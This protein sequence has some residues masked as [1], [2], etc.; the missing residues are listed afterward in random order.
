[1][2]LFVCMY[3]CMKQKTLPK[4]D[5]M[6]ACASRLNSHSLTN[7]PN[8]YAMRDWY[9]KTI[10][11]LKVY[12]AS[13]VAKAAA[14]AAEEEERKADAFGGDEIDET[15]VEAR[16]IE[17]VLDAKADEH[18]ERPFGLICLDIDGLGALND[19]ITHAIAD[20]VS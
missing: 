8:R 7:L 18:R 19:C 9:H 4:Q 2:Y 15:A 10:A 6:V 11:K 13:K 16:Q 14:S 17:A 20:K 3:V 1:M 12:T 5:D